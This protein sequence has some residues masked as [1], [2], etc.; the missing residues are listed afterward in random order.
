MIEFRLLGPLE[1]L[2]SGELVDLGGPKQRRVVAALALE[3][4]RVVS[5]DRLAS[6]VWEEE[7]PAT[8]RRQVQNAISAL[9]QTALGPLLVARDPGYLLDAAGHEIDVQRFDDLV[10]AASAQ[11]KSGDIAA[12]AGSLTAALSLWRGEPLDGIGGQAAE[13]AATRLTTKRLN[14]LLEKANC[15]LDLGQPDVAVAELAPAA[16]QFPLNEP[17]AALL[18]LAL[19][20]SGK[21][22]EAIARFHRTRQILATELGIDPG[23]ELRKRH[24]QMLRNDPALDFKAPAT[25]RNDLPRDTPHFTGRTAEL[26]ALLSTLDAG[27]T[28]VIQAIDGMGGVGKTALA[29]HAAH[30]LSPK[31]PD[32]Q[33]FID[34]HGHTPG[35]AAVSAEGALD[36]LLRALGVPPGGLQTKDEKAS[37]WRAELA[38]KR[39]LVVLDNAADA[40]QVAPLL[41]GAPGCTVLL[42]SRRRLVELDD[43][44]TLS[45]D[46]LSAADAIALFTASAG[47]QRIGGDNETVAEIVRLCG[48]LPL[49]ISIVA[50]RL[51]HRP[52]WTLAALAERLRDEHRRPALLEHEGQGVFTALSLSQHYLSEQQQRF[53]RL[54]GLNPGPDIGVHAAADLAGLPLLETELCLEELVDMHFLLQHEAGRYRLHDLIRDYARAI[55]AEVP[56]SEQDAARGRLFDH[57]Q[58]ATLTAAGFVAQ[59]QVNPRLPEQFSRADFIRTEEHARAW[60]STELANLISVAGQA[61]GLGQHETAYLIAEGLHGYLD[62]AGRLREGLVLTGHALAASVHLSTLAQASARLAHGKLLGLVGDNDGGIA[63]LIESL[64]LFR[65]EGSDAHS[66]CSAANALAIMHAKMGQFDEAFGYFALALSA[67]ERAGDRAREAVIHNNMGRVANELRRFESSLAHLKRALELAEE[68]GQLHA[69]NLA[70]G[71]MG[72]IHGQRGEHAEAVRF[73]ERAQQISREQGFRSSEARDLGNLAKALFLMGRKEEGLRSHL[74]AIAIQREIGDLY[75]EAFSQNN[76][77]AAYCELSAYQLAA[78]SGQR[79]VSIIEKLEIRGLA[80]EALTNLGQAHL[81]LGDP[82]LAREHWEKAHAILTD[83]GDPDAEVVAK[84]L[85]ELC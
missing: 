71:N 15:D 19:Y 52:T 7:P 45:L 1:V 79:A 59:G 21:Q 81:A 68:T 11:R 29:V 77:C 53:F 57:Y 13:T 36:V 35:Q 32:G 66:E 54:L 12:A 62:R 51:R 26:S 82:V 22:A 10:S 25:G 64:D 78:E 5:V 41:P 20:R 76:L 27:Q 43:A 17:L 33:L 40:A 2:A 46:V 60:L 70:L 4:G 18:L 47:A 31:F 38:G 28:V 69:A 3:P 61:N 48:Y 63:I 24:E 85:A 65:A 6:A 67:A 74:E 49:A 80:G 30:Q 83:L 84:K 75:G 8:A 44:R 39:I 14:A 16:D 34:L 42:T 56:P 9:R 50:A 55:V 37:R 72:I 73:F 23:P 58:N